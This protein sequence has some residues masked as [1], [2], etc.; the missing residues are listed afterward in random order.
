MKLRIALILMVSAAACAVE[1]FHLSHVRLLDGPFKHAQDLNL[2][3]LLQYDVDRLLAPFLKE[4]GLEPKG[5]DYLNWAGLD[6]HIGGHYLSAMAYYVA[7][8]GDAEAKRRMAYMVSELAACQ[9]RHGDGYV[10]GVP[11]G[12]AMWAQIARG[13]IRANG[14]GLN[15]KWVPWYNLQKLFAGLRDA[16]LVA[17]S[18]QARDMLIALS[19]WCVTLCGN[20]SDAQM[21]RMMVAEHGG[22]NEVLADVYAITGEA[23]YLE[24][25][26]RFSH[27]VL[28]DP[29]SQRRD[30][31]DNMHANTQ[32]PKAVGFQRIAELGGDKSF[33]DAALFFWE[34]VVGNRTLAFGGNSRR[35]HFPSAQACTDWVE[36]RE[37]PETCNTYNM[38]KLTAG[39]H[40][41][42]PEARYADYYERAMYNHILST[43]HPEHG[44]YV[45][46]TPVRPQH[47][48]VYSA[49][50]AAMWCCVGSGMENH[51]RY[52]EF[53][54]SHD[55]DSLYVNLFIASELEWAEKGV[56]VRQETRFP[57]EGKTT[58][59][60]LTDAPVT[61]TLKVRHP[62][63]VKSGQMGLTLGE[64]TWTADSESSSYVSIE[65]T[66]RNG[67]RLEI[68]LPMYTYV[69]E[70]PNVP[71][72]AAVLHG[73]IV[74]AARTGSEDLRGLVADDGRW[75]H[76]AHGRLLG[77]DDAPMLVG[78]KTSIPEKIR[79]LENEQGLRFKADGL[80]RPERF[81]DLVLEPFFRIHDVRY[82]MYW[83]ITSAQEYAA[84]MAE[85]REREQETLR[86]DQ[87]TVD[88]VI[89]GEQQ[90][91]V[92]HKFKSEGSE[93]EVFRGA[94]QR[95]VRAPGW[96]SYEMRVEPDKPL[97]LRVRYWGNERG[98]R[99]FDIL[100]DGEVL[101]T[102]T[103]SR[104][105]NREEF[106]DVRYPLP[107][108]RVEG[109]D[110]V[111]VTFRPHANNV[112][113]GIFDLRIVR[114]E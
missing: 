52:G 73:P 82:M 3:H 23:K 22:M 99:T 14:F 93:A 21:Q 108:E 77:L 53:I 70:M 88:R 16:W 40:R 56:R 72:Y 5:E 97:E 35:E 83:R 75:S 104:K 86:L 34:T 11:G 113:G 89:P 66:W 37:G 26:R 87:R 51:V 31:L 2:Q 111:T 10:G 112:A 6:G 59:T 39:L 100:V 36:E 24:L 48:R 64:R 80:I 46:F 61:F 74:L 102:E 9:K 1:P 25:A 28:L 17:G 69:E 62:A 60:V 96:F 19:D 29:L 94:S 18:E 98:S 13:D 50:N 32:V 33:G 57:D 78:D 45:Y 106:V 95:R 92:D 65:R 15:D 27:R 58:L 43:Q 68:S 91:E 79:P 90:P 12:R 7:A 109:K 67:E 81:T 110:Y 42:R 55:K 54:Y 4:A 38:L 47:Y 71:E 41:M 114:T 30:T 101:V 44:G 107:A 8:T 103:I 85:I 105:W 76:I 84:A 49:P 20:L 63:W